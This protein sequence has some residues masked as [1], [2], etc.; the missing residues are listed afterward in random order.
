MESYRLD[1]RIVEDDKEFLIQ[2][3]NDTQEGIIKTSLFVNGELLDAS[4]M[5]HS[6]E[7]SDAD[8]LEMVKT[9]HGDRK[10]ELEYLLKSFREVM[11]EGRPEMMYHLGTA[12]YYRRMYP[13]SQQLFQAALKLRHDYHEAYYYLAMVELASN[14]IDAAIKAGTKA[15]ELRPQFADYRNTLGEAYL[16]AGSSKRAVIEFEEAIR[17]NVYY[18]DAYFNLAMAFIL[19]AINKE[20]FD[21]A[22]DLKV[23]TTDL[24]KKAILIYPNYK[25]TTYEEA[26]AALTA[27]ELKRA[28]ALFKGVRNEKDERQR[29]EKS[30]YFHRFL[31]YTDWISQ[32]NVVERIN[33]LEKEI[34][35]NPGY[36]DLYYELAICYLH[37]AKFNWNKGIDYFKRAMEIN[38]N[39]AKARRSMDM[40]REHYL[41]LVDAIIDITEKNG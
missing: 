28:Y 35:R 17:Q 29:H 4:I 18:A 14:H 15:V 11:K 21:I 39:L 23:K 13:E 33:F 2:T 20:D 1:S 25:T 22:S 27:G 19:N 6:E 40:S 34:N 3:V 31:M 36:V 9:T 32:N 38:P 5:P 10:A 24:L 8:I 41:K 37:Q 12:L 16:A 7:I 30:T 26:V